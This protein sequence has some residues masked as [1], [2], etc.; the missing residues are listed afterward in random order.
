MEMFRTV[1]FAIL[2]ALCVPA[3]AS[4]LSL[5]ISRFLAGEAVSARVDLHDIEAR[6]DRCHL[7]VTLA[8]PRL[9]RDLD[10]R[11]GTRGNLGSSRN[12]LYWVGPTRLR[13]VAKDTTILLTSRARYES[14]TIVK[15]FGKKLKNKNFRATKTVDFL[16]RPSWDAARDRLSLDYEIQGMRNFPGEIEQQLKRHGVE[17]GGTTAFEVPRDD[18][19]V[20]ALDPRIET[21]LVFAVAG[22]GGGLAVRTTV[23]VTLPPVALFLGVGVDTCAALRGALDILP[24][25]AAALALGLIGRL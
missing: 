24:E 5:D 4:A 11:I 8:A 12:R 14:W 15:V 18:E 23:S 13:G 17:F 20:Q 9:W 2:T 22:E 10:A 16:L 7:D 6:G 1:C 21:P 25:K 3:T 19:T